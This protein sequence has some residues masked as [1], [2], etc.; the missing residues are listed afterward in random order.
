MECYILKPLVPLFADIDGLNVLIPFH[1]LI[2][3]TITSLT[4][5]HV[6][7]INEIRFNLC[8]KFTN[9]VQ[10]FTIASIS[11]NLFEY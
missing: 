7:T 4:E 1:F 11:Q 8:Q 5:P 2:S 3:K 10:V 6:A 9:S